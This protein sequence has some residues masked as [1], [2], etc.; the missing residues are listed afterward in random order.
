M[1]RWCCLSPGEEQLA[2]PPMRR[3]ITFLFPDR[4]GRLGYLTRGLVWLVVA[5]VADAGQPPDGLFRRVG[6]SDAYFCVLIG[7]MLYFLFAVLMPRNRDIGWRGAMHLLFF[8]PLLNVIL[9]LGL[10][11]IPG[12]ARVSEGRLAP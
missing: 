10:L 6:V 1:T 4:V 12:K 9:A 5:C 11:F 2:F 3:L 8:I 7:L